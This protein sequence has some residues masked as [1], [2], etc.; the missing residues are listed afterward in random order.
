MYRKMSLKKENESSPI[1]KALCVYGGGFRAMSGASAFISAAMAVEYNMINPGSSSIENHNNAYNDAM[2]NLMSRFALVSTNSGGSWFAYALQMSAT[3]NNVLKEMTERYL[4]MKPG[5]HNTGKENPFYRSFLAI[6]LKNVKAWNKKEKNEMSVCTKLQER[7]GDIA[8]EGLVNDMSLFVKYSVLEGAGHN[9]SIWDNLVEF[10]MSPLTEEVELPSWYRKVNLDWFINVAVHLPTLGPLTCSDPNSEDVNDASE[11][12]YR[13]HGIT[14]RSI[15]PDNTYLKYVTHYGIKSM[16]PNYIG[17][18]VKLQDNEFGRVDLVPAAFKVSSEMSEALEYNFIS[19]SFKDL[20]VE[21]YIT[22][23]N[24]DDPISPNHIETTRVEPSFDFIK[25]KPLQFKLS[26]SSSPS[27]DTELRKTMEQKKSTKYRF[28]EWLRSSSSGNISTSNEIYR[29]MDEVLYRVVASSAA[30]GASHVSG[31]LGIF[32]GENSMAFLLQWLQ[33]TAIDVGEDCDVDF[34]FGSLTK[35]KNQYKN[36]HKTEPPENILEWELKGETFAEQCDQYLGEGTLLDY[37]SPNAT[38]DANKSHTSCSLL[39]ILSCSCS[40]NGA[41][42]GSNSTPDL[43]EQK[44]TLREYADLFPLNIAD[45]GYVDNT[46]I[47]RAVMDS[48]S[49]IS[50]FAF[51]T[52]DFLSLFDNNEFQNGHPFTCSF[53][54]FDCTEEEGNYL[55]NIVDDDDKSYLNDQFIS[56]N[57]KFVSRKTFRQSKG[58]DRFLKKLYMCKFRDLRIKYNPYYF[59]VDDTKKLENDVVQEL[60][61]I[62]AIETLEWKGMGRSNPDTD[63]KGYGVWVDEIH[64]ALQ[65][66]FV[67][68]EEK[69]ENYIASKDDKISSARSFR[70]F[71]F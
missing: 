67:E 50:G 69:G 62:F 37:D 12:P 22:D 42:S 59:D 71:L 46:G 51:N 5:K 56:Q 57:F 61:V 54:I 27:S 66:G 6:S 55:K 53:A 44:I 31:N 19:P 58:Q 43:P 16:K 17:N 45:G 23:N 36:F 29:K 1:K 18:Y 32:E 33:F 52:S 47:A 48:A 9:I 24:S 15:R 7:A 10:L 34:H 70:D 40:S 68:D 28:S 2:I 14:K 30:L 65:N 26:T 39:S 38:A 60:S 4:V 3:F 25:Q 21:Y 20:S 41:S 64:S 13:L 35:L 63:L 8:L 11:S 49:H